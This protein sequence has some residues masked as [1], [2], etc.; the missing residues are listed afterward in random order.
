MKKAY[1]S[2]ELE[3]SFCSDKDTIM[4]SI[5]T[6]DVGGGDWGVKDEL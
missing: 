4:T 1:L 5:P 6:M 3:L 2:P